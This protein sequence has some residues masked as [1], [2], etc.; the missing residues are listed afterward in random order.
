M[1]PGHVA[2]TRP[3][4]SDGLGG[5]RSRARAA[6]LAVAWQRPVAVPA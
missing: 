3:S 4:G 5:S 1:S 2:I 6:R